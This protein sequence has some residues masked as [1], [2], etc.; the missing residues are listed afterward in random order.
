MNRKLA[1]RTKAFALQIIGT[2]TAVPKT[3]IGRVI[4]KQM[5][6][7]GTSVGAH[8]REAFRSRS[9]AELV[10]KL[11]VAVQETDE[12]MYWM[13]LLIESNVMKDDRLQPLLKEADELISIMVTSVKTIKDRR[14]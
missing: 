10:S 2:Y 8:C 11:E 9:D 4:G 7:S 14:R 5:L 13:E 6:R 3:D 1:D 12:T